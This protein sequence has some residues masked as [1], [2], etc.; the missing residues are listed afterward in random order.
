MAIIY[1]YP[2]DTPKTTDLLLGSSMSDGKPTKTF[3]IASLVGLVNAPASPGSVEKVKTAS[4]TFINVVGG[5]ITDSGTIT[6]S[7][8]A[9]GTPSY[10]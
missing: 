7:L 3:T 9:G 10:W 2:T 4:S 1:S 8:S 5:D 6:A